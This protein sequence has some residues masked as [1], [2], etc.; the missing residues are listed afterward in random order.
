MLEKPDI[1]E[2]II[3][4]CLHEKFGLLVTQ[5]SFL[6]LGAD[7]NTAVFHAIS[8]DGTPYFVKMRKGAFEETAVSIP[9]ILSDQG[10][11]QIIPPLRTKTGQLWANLDTFK[12]ILYPFIN[13][14]NG[15]EV[16][17]SDRHWID[18]GRTLK[19]IHT[20]I[21]PAALKKQIQQETY[22][23]KGR[24]TVRL[25][26]ERV[27]MDSCDDP[28]AA[29]LAVF[30]RTKNAQ[31]LHLIKVAE[32]MVETLQA[33]PPEFT[34]CHSDIHAGNILID[35]ND[36]LY[37]VD[38]DNPI[39]APKERDLMFAGGGQFGFRRTPKEEET[40]FYRGYGKTQINPTALAY[41]RYE[42]IIQDIAAYCEQLFLTNEGGRDREQSLRYLES[43]FLPNGTIEI[44]YES[45][46]TSGYS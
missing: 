31:I 36:N 37:I 13:G 3:I 7:Q 2:K 11:H 44:A 23:P 45:D 20:A 19:S 17:L 46:R 22:P 39:L 27:K 24:E 25:F 30:L 35:D 14:Q 6:P 8:G 12:L 41:Y 10:I 38:W 16:E 9:K 32:R 4:S 42:R 43:N 5:V 40:L 33:D 15:Y 26:L 18:F 28:V 21:L 1:Q 34:I 29:K